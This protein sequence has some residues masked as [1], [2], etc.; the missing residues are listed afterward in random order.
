MDMKT[1]GVF[2]DALS[3]LSRSIDRSLTKLE[4]H[5]NE[6]VIQ[7]YLRYLRTAKNELD[8]AVYA[9]DETMT[10]QGDESYH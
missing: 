4:P 2:S 1:M 3:D 8:G 7:D 10:G 9:C 6:P 5:S